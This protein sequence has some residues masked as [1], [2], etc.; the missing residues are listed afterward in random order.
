MGI[1][2]DMTIRVLSTEPFL[3]QAAGPGTR[4]RAGWD[5]LAISPAIVDAKLAALPFGAVVRV[6]YLVPPVM[7]SAPP[8]HMTAL[9]P[10]PAPVAE[11]AL[12]AEW[13]PGHDEAHIQIYA[14]GH[15]L[16]TAPPHPLIETTL[17]QAEL[18][19]LLDS[20]VRAKFDALATPPKQRDS[21]L[22]NR[23]DFSSR[24][25]LLCDR[26]EQVDLA[27]HA[28]EVA[29]IAAAFAHIRDQTLARA[30]PLLGVADTGWH[31]HIFSWPAGAPPLAEDWYSAKFMAA[32]QA[33]AGDNSSPMYRQVP[34]DLAAALAAAEGGPRVI[35]L[36]HGLLWGLAV[37][38]CDTCRAGTYSSII[39]EHESW[40]DAP[41]WAP[42]FSTIGEPGLWLDGLDPRF[43]TLAREY[44]QRGEIYAVWQT[45][46]IPAPK[47]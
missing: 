39:L 46:A 8:P 47:P 33:A 38:R 17:S 36:D 23:F 43:K 20:F 32:K 7:N 24:V 6:H 29:P 2:H 19:A 13:H 34:D 35:V 15:A 14:D 27:D 3:F 9:P 11:P 40:K 4:K 25:V 21:D 41:D 26:F 10:G 31:P 30:R 18:D 28:A 44:R 1:D 22:Y 12:I 37:E 42:D 45:E 16:V 5:E